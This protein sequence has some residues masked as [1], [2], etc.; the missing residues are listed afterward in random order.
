M[1]PVI[2]LSEKRTAS[3]PVTPFLE[4]SLEGFGL[5]SMH[6][7]SSNASLTTES[8]SVELKNIARSASVPLNKLPL[9]PPRKPVGPNSG[10]TV[11]LK[12]ITPRTT[13]GTSGDDNTATK[14]SESITI[15][16]DAE[17]G[18]KE[19]AKD[20]D[21]EIPEEEA[22]C[23]ICFEELSDKH[24]ET[25]KME[26]S[27]RGEMALA[28]KDCALKWFSIKGNRT[29]DVCGLE[30][31]NL[32]V[33]V[34]RQG[35]QPSAITRPANQ[36]LDTHTRVWQD[37]PV[38]VM[39]SMLVYFC[40]LEQLLVGQ[41]GS[42]ALAIS[43]PFSC[44]LGLLAAITAANLV[45]K[46]YVWLYATCQLALVVCFAHIFYDVV[47]VESVLSILLAAFVGF[48]IAMVTSTLV[49]EYNNW[50][51]RTAARAQREREADGSGNNT[52]Q[53]PE[54]NPPTADPQHDHVLLQMEGGGLASL[55]LQS[56]DNRQGQ[57][58][59]LAR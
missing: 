41:M 21:E 38:L 44:V 53:T 26:C 2:P 27:C 45:E 42:G 20:G 54:P 15:Q 47:H 5:S 13:V 9:P 28:H 22:V 50:K 37:V 16:T 18:E 24:G 48:G 4:S 36:L 56:A 10:A 35:N 40:F 51:R 3:M 8:G 1:G 46:R 23:R 57:P 30:V 29:C 52:A 14:D 49:I 43:L 34:V 55:W 6:Q 39:L 19:H 32:P 25:F 11:L 59:Q 12:S 33:T 17:K 7:S 58:S 31:C